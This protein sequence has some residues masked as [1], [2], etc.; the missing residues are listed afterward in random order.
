MMTSMYEKEDETA[1]RDEFDEFGEMVAHNL[2]N[3]KSEY[4]KV[5]IH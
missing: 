5:T 1:K 4:S 3:L 2:R